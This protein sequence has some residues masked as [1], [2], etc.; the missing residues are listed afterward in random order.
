M[1]MT[2]KEFYEAHKNF[3]FCDKNGNEWIFLTDPQLTPFK[4]VNKDSE[5]ARVLL[6]PEGEKVELTFVYDNGTPRI[7]NEDKI[8]F[9]DEIEVSDS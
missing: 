6:S 2:K 4:M 3:I 7:F 5:P 1:Q 8:K 9:V